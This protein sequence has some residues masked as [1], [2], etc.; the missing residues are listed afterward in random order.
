MTEAN[1]CFENAYYHVYSRG[2][3]RSE[4]FKDHSD[5]D[6]FLKIL[7]RAFI[8]FEIKVHAYCLIMN[9]YHL[10]IQ[11]P[12]A[13]LPEAMK[14]INECYA[15]YFIKKYKDERDGKVFARRYQKHL[16]QHELYSKTLFVYIMF[17]MYRHNQKLKPDQWLYTSYRAITGQEKP[18]NFLP[19]N[20]FKD[21]FPTIKHFYDFA[22]NFDYGWSPSQEAFAKTFLGDTDFNIEIIKN[23]INLRDDRITGIGEMRRLVN[24]EAV[25]SYITSLQLDSRERLNYTIYLLREFTSM[26]RQDISDLTGLTV[27]SITKRHVALKNKIDDNNYLSEILDERSLLEYGYLE[28]W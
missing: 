2:M 7:D 3:N 28:K 19:T 6:Y 20:L 8:K 23:H 10:Y 27:H 22:Q 5:Y 18:R 9:H 21:E 13:N 14:Y 17:N 25:L 1:I 12:K 11:T 24:K 16:V 4:I 26:K 15:K